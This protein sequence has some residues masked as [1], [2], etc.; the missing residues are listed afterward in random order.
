MNP[1]DTLWYPGVFVAMVVFAAACGDDE[2]TANDA[3]TTPTTTTAS[4]GSTASTGG[5]GGEPGTGGAAA[6]GGN[7]G[8]GEAPFNCVTARETALGPIDAVSTGSVDIL[9][10]TNGVREV[11]VD[12]SAGGFMVA[13]EN[14]GVYIDLASATR[15]DITDPAAFDASTWDLAI[16]RVA[17][18]NNSAHS[19]AGD[20]AAAFLAGATFADVDLADATSATLAQ[21]VWFDEMCEYET[22][23]TGALLTTMSDWYDY[24]STTFQVAPKDGVY[25]VRGADGSTY[26]KVQI[27]AYYANPDGTPGMTSGRYVLR[28][29]TL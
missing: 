3:T 28:I 5:N 12:A 23:P 22:D 25:V 27:L 11:F 1:Y 13:A 21:E 29:A 6:T 24:D 16:K 20:G 15:V 8:G 10:D 17:M 9:D 2:P 7:G 18:R 19:G 4:G 26:F 14:P